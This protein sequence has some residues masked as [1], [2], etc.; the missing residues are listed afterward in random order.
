MANTKHGRDPKRD[1]VAYNS[2]MKTR[3]SVHDSDDYESGYN[4][5]VCVE[6]KVNMAQGMSDVAYLD[7]G[8]NKMILT[9]RK[10]MKNLERADRQMTTANKGKLTITSVDDA[11]NIKGF[12]IVLWV[13]IFSTFTAS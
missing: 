4:S 1:A 12:H 6:E 5:M 7:S 3:V 11:G 9:S 8:C 10:R 2:E 13:V